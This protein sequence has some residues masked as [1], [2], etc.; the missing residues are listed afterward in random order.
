MIPKV[1]TV[2]LGA[3]FSLGLGISQMSR[4]QKILAFLDVLGNWDPSLILVMTAAVGVYYSLQKYILKFSGP[5]YEKDFVLPKG[6]AIDKRL[7][8]GAV[9]FG[10]GWGTTGFCPGPSITAL[11]SGTSEVFVFFLGMYGG[12]LLNRVTNLKK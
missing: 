4:P 1:L 8:C 11:A 10:I 9:I 2:I 5:K 3:L 7:V 12:M 6:N